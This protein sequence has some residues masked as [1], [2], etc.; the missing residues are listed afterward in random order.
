MK[1][2]DLLK[3][4]S[5]LPLLSVSTSLAI[6]GTAQAA[7][8]P[9][10]RVR[11][12]DPG[13][14]DA[15]AW[16]TLN[17]AV[18][19][20]LI[21]VQPLFAPC[22]ENTEGDACANILKSMRNPYY[23]GDQPAGTQTSGW[24]GAWTS[25]SS[26]YAVKARNAQDVAAAVDFA[27]RK[28][29]RLAVKGGGHSYLGTSNAAD[30]LLIWTRGMNSVMLQDAFVG[31]GCHGRAE[32]VQAVSAG[33]GA[34]WS[35]LYDAVTTVAGRYVQGG[36]CLSVGVAGLVQSA[37]FGSFSRGFGTAAASLLEA[38]IVTADG[39]VLVANECLNSDLFWALKGGG[40]GS[41]GVVTRLTL[42]THALPKNFGNAWGRIKARSDDAFQRL[43]ARFITH[44][45]EH[46]FNPHWGEQVHF[47]PDNT[48]QISMA[49]QGLDGAA[50]QAAWQ[51]FFDWV[52]AA[53]NDFEL[54]Q[55]PGTWVGD[56]RG[57]WKV[58]GD[59][60]Q[61][62]AREGASAHH[63]WW[64]G[65]DSEQ[66]GVFIHGYDSLWLPAD[67]LHENDG[68][69]LADAVFR[70]SRY[71]KVDLHINKGLAGAPKEVLAAVANT[72]T[73]PAVAKAFALAIIADGEAPAFPG[74]P[75][76]S[77]DDRAAREDAEKIDLATAEL[78]KI[79][80]R[81]GSYVSESNYFNASWQ[82]AYWGENYAKLAKIKQKYDPDGLFFVH[83]G[84]GSEDWSPDGFERLR[85][86]S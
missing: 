12:S 30:S 23:L 72:A 70:A 73:N 85:F 4:A 65:G 45:R 86:R 84:V 55:E 15:Q 11:P 34:M 44:Y 7:S 36:G 46:L 25:A 77:V 81:A 28:N 76:R 14:P 50:A 67:L 17:A 5:T 21:A 78:R 10:R 79:V 83:H 60:M 27:R 56:S 69:T 61:V 43:I 59:Y 9:F 33:A 32:P 75:R 8:R 71:K 24:L 20:N 37:G 58:G 31:Q 39:K 52:R 62:D 18:G 35:D 80:P 51:S 48:F 26:A 29:L 57:Y 68:R 54:A 13:W 2:R 40:G 6:P 64:K 22:T 53:A 47:S 49:S 3:A 16:Q 66:V 19:G 41:W 82:D 38:E 42:R 63:G 1:R 74:M